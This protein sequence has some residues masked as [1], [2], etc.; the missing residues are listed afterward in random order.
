MTRSEG[1][2][3]IVCDVFDRRHLQ[4]CVETT[5]LDVIIHQ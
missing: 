4:E 5:L 2:A 1:A 3:A